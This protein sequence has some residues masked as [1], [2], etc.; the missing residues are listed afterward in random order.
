MQRRRRG[1]AI[2]GPSRQP[3]VTVGRPVVALVGGGFSATALVMN[4]LRC[5][6]SPLH[7]KI[8]EA[9]QQQY[10]RGLAYGH[11]APPREP[12][13]LLNVPAGRIGLCQDDESDFHRWW[14]AQ[15]GGEARDF[16]PRASYGD[17]L[18]HRLAEAIERRPDCRIEHIPKAV[19]SLAAHASQ[20]WVL[21]DSQNTLH[22]AHQVAL[23]HGHSQ[24]QAPEGCWDQQHWWPD[25]WA[26]E[27]QKALGSYGSR[28]VLLIGTGLTAVDL[29]LQRLESP[30]AGPVLMVSRR[31]LLPQAHRALSAPPVEAS[32]ELGPLFAHEGRAS[33]LVRNL[34]SAMR[35]QDW[36]DVLGALRH[37]TPRL[38]Q[39][40]PAAARA[41]LMRH[42]LPYWDSHRHRAAHS[43]M[44]KVNA[45]IATGRAR[46]IAGRVLGGAQALPGEGWHV[47]LRTRGSTQVVD[48]H[49]AAVFNCTSPVNAGAQAAAQLE[50]DLLSRGNARRD[51]LRLGLEVDAR[52][53]V[54]HANGKPQPGLWCVGP[55]LRAGWW[56]AT[57]IQELRQHAATVAQAICRDLDDRSP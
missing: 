36:R 52:H 38:W 35:A 23:T 1:A 9:V 46:R 24:R 15:G 49:V 43:V 26:P 19:V 40:L 31:G 11:A 42:A 51:A 17:Y 25:P 18:L 28:P 13:P 7:L 8:F 45:A 32:L 53:R 33:R 37:E 27:A 22:A 55:A 50:A 3:V 12:A 44:D 41:S 56:E 30:A 16:A 20:G 5:A 54:L 10:G 2:A 4:L 14:Q 48:L 34:R 57:A 6:R 21:R 29:L 47:R 39:S